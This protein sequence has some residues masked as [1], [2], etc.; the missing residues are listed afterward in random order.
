MWK[1]AVLICMKNLLV[2]VLVPYD[3]GLSLGFRSSL[4]CPLSC[5]ETRQYSHCTSRLGPFWSRLPFGLIWGKNA[6]WRTPH[7]ARRATDPGDENKAA[8]FPRWITPCSATR[9]VS[10]RI[11]FSPM[12]LP[13]RLI[14]LL[15]ADW[16]KKA[17][18]PEINAERQMPG[19]RSGERC[20]RLVVR[21]WRRIEHCGSAR[22][23][24]KII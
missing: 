12:L 13:T 18:S 22:P 6:D 5:L 17:A 11:F 10:L 24:K 14:H 8:K 1:T 15:G 2:H 9:P 19:R 16:A 7:S 4:H 23:E 3:A 20:C 21:T